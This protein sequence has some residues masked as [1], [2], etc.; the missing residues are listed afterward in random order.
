M[1]TLDVRA[2]RDRA[3]VVAVAVFQIVTDAVRDWFHGKPL[4]RT[5]VLAAVAAYLR[6]NYADLERQIVNDIAA[7]P[8]HEPNEFRCKDG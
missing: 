2:T 8:T 7:N 5:A 1:T 4:N 6:E 3:D